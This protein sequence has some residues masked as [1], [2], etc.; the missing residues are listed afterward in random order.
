MYDTC[1]LCGGLVDKELHYL[2]DL[3]PEVDEIVPV[4]RG[5]DPLDWDN[6]KLAHRV[7]NRKKGNRVVTQGVSSIREELEVS[8][9]WG[10]DDPRKSTGAT[11]DIGLI[12]PQRRTKT[13]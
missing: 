4:S 6:V 2:N 1:H 3:A 13:R 8:R 9:I 11:T 7:C 5:G 12:S 10:V